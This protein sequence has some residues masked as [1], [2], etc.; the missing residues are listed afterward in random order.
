[1]DHP[2]FRVVEYDRQGHASTRLE[3]PHQNSAPWLDLLAGHDLD[4]DPTGILEPVA[5]E[6]QRLDLA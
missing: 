6:M 2:G 3:G 4:L 5:R 1:M